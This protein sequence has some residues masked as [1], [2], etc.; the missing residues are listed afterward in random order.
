MP[1]KTVR[2]WR[3]EKPKLGLMSAARLAVVPSTFVRTL[4]CGLFPD[5]PIQRPP[6]PLENAGPVPGPLLAEEACGRIPR[7]VLPVPQ[8]APVGRKGQQDP[9]RPGEGAGEMRF[10]TGLRDAGEPLPYWVE[11]GEGEGRVRGGDVKPLA[12]VLGRLPKTQKPL[13]HMDTVN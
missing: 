11:G 5:V 3:E 1:L 6:D 2:S 8:P 4:Q 10:P 13:T 9:Y 12:W 7:S